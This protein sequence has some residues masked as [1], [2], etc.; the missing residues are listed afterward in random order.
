M[1]YKRSD[2]KPILVFLENGSINSSVIGRNASVKRVFDDGIRLCVVKPEIH[3]SRMVYHLV[4]RGRFLGVVST[5]FDGMTNEEAIRSFVL[6]GESSR[7]EKALLYGDT[8]LGGADATVKGFT[9]MGNRTVRC[10]K[11]GVGCEIPAGVGIHFNSGSPWV[12]PMPDVFVIVENVELFYDLSWLSRLGFDNRF[13]MVACRSP[14]SQSG[15]L[16]DW[17]AAYLPSDVVLYYFGDLDLSG[18][19][20][21]KVEF[22]SFFGERIHFFL[23]QGAA[24]GIRNGNR[25]NYRK[26]ASSNDGKVRLDECQWLI[27]L[28]HRY[29][30][31]LEQEIF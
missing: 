7:R 21:Y 13:V 15:V 29:H 10:F 26:Q 31:G 9:V 11:D 6:G 23:P 22:K 19:Q 16:K 27:D 25:S 14:L 12:D 28:I 17:L 4:D 5:V 3:G 2:L 1:S 30:S 18:I 20:K 8:K 24:E